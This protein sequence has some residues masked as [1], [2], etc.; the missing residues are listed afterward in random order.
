MLDIIL[1]ARRE[2]QLEEEEAGAYGID[3]LM[4][5][6]ILC[7]DILEPWSIQYR[8]QHENTTYFEL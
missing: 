6:D 5:D 1:E 3:G 4:V 8:T 2:G 7:T